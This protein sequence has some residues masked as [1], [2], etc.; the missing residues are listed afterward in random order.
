M[1]QLRLGLRGLGIKHEKGTGLGFHPT[2][3]ASTL[4]GGSKS[5]FLTP[6]QQN[7][8]WRLKL[9]RSLLEITLFSLA[10]DYFGVFLALFK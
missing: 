4:S 2:N 5:G 9:D 7:C 6:S 3:P 8:M 10:T 1:T